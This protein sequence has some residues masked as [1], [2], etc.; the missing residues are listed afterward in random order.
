MLE[1]SKVFYFIQYTNIKYDNTNNI[2]LIYGINN[3]NINII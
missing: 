2:N 1:T 3:N